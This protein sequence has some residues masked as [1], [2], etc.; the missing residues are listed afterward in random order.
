VLVVQLCS[1]VY[2]YCCAIINI[3][4]VITYYSCFKFLN[5]MI[6]C[7]F[8]IIVIFIFYMSFVIMYMFF[9][10]LL[11]CACYELEMSSFT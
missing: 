10:T 11:L 8:C 7:A 4:L 6:L 3:R 9:N 1:F 5:F 2:T